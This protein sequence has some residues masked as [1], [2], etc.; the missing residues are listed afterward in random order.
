MA[1]CLA[2]DVPQGDLEKYDEVMRKLEESGGQLG[3]GQTFHAAGQTNEGFTVI[4]MWNSREDFDRFLSGRLGQALQE[5]GVPQAAGEGDTD[6][7][8]LALMR[9]RRGELCS[10]RLT[11]ARIERRPK[12]SRHGFG[13]AEVGLRFGVERTGIEPVTSGLQSRRSPS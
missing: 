11:S 9:L 4:D 6:P 1:V 13:G 2:I 7:Q 3:E 8:P 12:R 5:V 10:A